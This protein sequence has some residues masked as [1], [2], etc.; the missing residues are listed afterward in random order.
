MTPAAQGGDESMSWFVHNMPVSTDYGLPVPQPAIYYGFQPYDYA[1]APNLLGEID[2]PGEDG[3]VMTNY[4]GTGGVALSSV[5]RK[6]F[7]AIYFQDRNVFFTTK[8]TAQTRVLFRRN[9]SESIQRIT[10]F[11]TLDNDPYLVLTD[12]GFFWIQDAYTLSDH[13][14]YAQTIDDKFNYIRNSIKIVIDA[15]NGDIMYYRL[16]N[17]PIAQAYDRMY[18]GLMRP[19]ADMPAQLRSH[20]RYPK[21][22]FEIQMHIFARY[23]QTHPESFYLQDDNWELSKSHRGG[24]AMIMRPYYLT[25][26]D[27][28]AEGGGFMLVFPLSPIERNNLRALAVAACD[29]DRYGKITVLSFPRGKQV[30]G[31]SQINSLVDQDTDISQQLTLWDQ[32]GSEVQ[33]G[34]IIILPVDDFLLYIQPVYL[35][36]AT[37]LKIPELKRLIVS[38]GEVAAMGLTLDIAIGELEKKI[39]TRQRQRRPRSQRS[40]SSSSGQNNI[41]RQPDVKS[42]A[43]TSTVTAPAAQEAGAASGQSSKSN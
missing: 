31:P 4:A 5:F 23:H 21:D 34:R 24:Q 30:Y 2:Y 29:G 19:M 6:L 26:D 43:I 15:Y 40:I 42:S 20:L 13:Y 10:P 22:L 41:S 14:P 12:A 7:F 35:S 3:N 38:D 33:R 36:S 39:K 1:L 16:G 28:N 17:D 11:L 27:L 18:P 32:A 8:T 37:R 9:I 25:L